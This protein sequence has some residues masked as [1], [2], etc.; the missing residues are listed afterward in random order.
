MV[1]LLSRVTTPGAIRMAGGAI[2]DEATARPLGDW[3]RWDSV[4]MAAIRSIE[5]ALDT[6]AVDILTELEADFYY[7]PY[8]DRQERDRVRVGRD[9]AIAIPPDFDFA[10]VAGL[11]TEMVERLTTAQPSTLGQ[12]TRIRGI[13]PAATTA[14]LAQLRRRAA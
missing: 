3:L 10:N 12:V 9:E 4:D 2:P 6:V 1:R 7:Q 13:T 14:V 8:L 11:S 5:P